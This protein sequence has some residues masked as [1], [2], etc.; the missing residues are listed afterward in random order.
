MATD[1]EVLEVLKIKLAAYEG[2]GMTVHAKNVQTKINQ[3]EKKAAAGPEVP[4]P[5]EK[6]PAAAKT[7]AKSAAKKST[8]KK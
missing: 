7:A 3:L 1:A 5:V 8:K 4:K 6:A 2:A